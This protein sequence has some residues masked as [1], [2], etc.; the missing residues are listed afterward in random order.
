ML[1]PAPLEPK[2]LVAGRR[3]GYSLDGAFYT[4]PEVFDLDLEAIF[5][6]HWIFVGVEP[7]VAEPGDF[8][9]RDVGRDS[10]IILRDDAG[11]VRAH[12]NV[13]RHRG[14]RLL[15]SDRGT[16]G[17]LTCPY[18]QWT[19]ELTGELIHAT[20][21]GDQFDR[22]CHG[23]KPVHLRSIEGLLFVCLADPPPADIDEMARVMVPRLAPHDLRNTRIAQQV[24]LIE[25]GNW[26]LTMENNR[27]CYHCACNHPE[28]SA[29][30]SKF[31]VGFAPD[32]DDATEIE[33]ATAYAAQEKRLLADW[34]ARGL[35]S[36]PVEVLAGRPTGFRTQRLVIDG[37][38]ESHTPD[39]KAACRRLLGGLTDPRLGDLHFWTQPNSW[40]HIFS[41]HAVTFAVFPLSADR[42]LLRTTWL[43]HKDA[44]EGVDYDLDN[45]TSVWRA[46]NE[47]DAALVG[48][49]H[50]GATSRAY[51]PGPYSPLTEGLVDQFTTWYVERLAAYL[52]AD[53]GSDPAGLTPKHIAS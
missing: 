44:V 14:A 5:A 40:H 50:R 15:T 24:D 29:S 26:K 39:T 53:E 17:K 36:N 42:T 31:S 28:L 7:E 47:Q 10:I 16:V 19:Y 25:E 51:E 43:V 1:M 45:L 49:A 2:Q 3:P 6:R 52:N 30:Y 34:E 46:T 32:P 12:F 9:T 41:D 27:E 48:L 23:L 22:S 21:M 13:C 33:A 38:G 20:Q 37:A 18:H 35:P 11:V 4:A 8:I